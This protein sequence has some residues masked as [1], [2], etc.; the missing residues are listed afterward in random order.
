MNPTRRSCLLALTLASLTPLQALA[1]P[2]PKDDVMGAIWK[3][4]LKREGQPEEKGEFRV[5]K[6]EIFLEDKKIGSVHKKDEDETTL[7]FGGAPKLNGTAT[8]RKTNKKPPVAS[9]TLKKSDGTTWDM[10]VQ[11]FDR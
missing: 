1:K 11:I 10:H 8:L 3:Y 9:G 4:T 5:Y 6:D 2:K 7:T